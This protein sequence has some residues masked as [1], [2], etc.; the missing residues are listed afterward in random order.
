MVELELCSLIITYYVHGGHS[1]SFFS[2]TVVLVHMLSTFR[3]ANNM[4]GTAESK[5]VARLLGVSIIKKKASR[6]FKL[7]SHFAFIIFSPYY[8]VSN[9]NNNNK[10]VRRPKKLLRSNSSCSTLSAYSQPVHSSH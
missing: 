1:S 7:H 10:L 5:H 8:P 4:Q 2:F 3:L 9:N 6:I